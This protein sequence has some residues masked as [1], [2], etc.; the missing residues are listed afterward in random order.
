MK[1]AVVIDTW[2]PAIGGGQVNVW[3]ISKRLA[4]KDFEIDILTRNNGEDNLKKIKY[5]KINKYGKVSRPE[6]IPARLLFIFWLFFFLLKNKYDIIHVHPFLPALVCSLAGFI[7]RIPVVFTVHG[8][9]LFD[10]AIKLSFGILLEKLILFKIPYTKVISVTRAFS[11]ISNVNKNIIVIPNGIDVEKFDEVN[12]KK[13]K[14]PK[15]IWVGRFDKVKRVEDLIK[16]SQIVSKKI[17]DVKCF[18]VGYGYEEKNLKKLKKDLN[19]KSIV[20]VGRLTEK[21]LI[22]QYKSSH[23]FVLPSSSEGQPITLL[24]AQ[25][26]KL[27][28]IATNVGGIPEIIKNKVNGMLVESSDPQILSGAIMQVLENPNDY[29]ENGYKMVKKYSWDNISVKTRQVYDSV[30]R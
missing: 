21:E 28:V 18:L 20:F 11:S 27:P 7:K 10:K 22:R 23:L 5:L 2:F 24:E 1:I 13:A 19:A 16:A 8:T 4:K 17:K 14:F 15:I 26:A 3:E 6:S 25:A 12:V 29:G 9:R 30:S